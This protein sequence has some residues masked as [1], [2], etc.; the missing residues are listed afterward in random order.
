LFLKGQR[1]TYK[2]SIGF[3]LIEMVITITIVSIIAA[4]IYPIIIMGV[5]SY[6]NQ[7][8]RKE[9]VTRGRL[10]IEKMTRDIRAS[11][12]NTILVKTNLNTNDTVEF[13]NA[14]F[15]SS[16]STIS[17][18]S[19][20]YTLNDNSGLAVIA[21]PFIVIYNTNPSS[22]YNYLSDPTPSTY[23]VVSVTSNTVTFSA[24]SKPF[25]PYNR[26][27]MSDGPVAYSLNSNGELIRY[28][29]YNPG[30][31]YLSDSTEQNIL[32]DNVESLSFSYVSGTLTNESVL[33]IVFKITM[34][35]LSMDFHQEVHI[36]NA[37]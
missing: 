30:G 34:E 22:Y 17:G 4:V 35:G 6:R 14:V 27:S 7:V 37:P 9:I 5:D 15:Y 12:P 2:S 13:G 25:S 1:Q 16:Y 23:P 18:F 26:Y 3:T 29:G 28:S 36:R 33:S 8:L 31:S 20:P 11:V 21:A 24:S 10:A 32:I 19:S